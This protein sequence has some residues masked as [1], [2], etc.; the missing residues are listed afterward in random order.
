MFGI[1]KAPILTI[2]PP[3]L[4]RLRDSRTRGFAS[5]ALKALR[6]DSDADSTREPR[7]LLINRGFCVNSVRET[8]RQ[9]RKMKRRRFQ[10]SQHPSG[11]LITA[12][13][14][15][16]DVASRW[17]AAESAAGSEEREKKQLA[18]AQNIRYD[19]MKEA[20]AN[21]KQKR[22]ETNSMSDMRVREPK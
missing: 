6:A 11:L 15:L 1:C 21:E 10:P 20:P 4:L 16:E 19:A 3:F 17:K 9:S 12:G 18:R 14:R 22:N 5:R 2:F 13:W 8:S 7:I